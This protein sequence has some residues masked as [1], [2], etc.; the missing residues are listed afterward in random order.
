MSLDNFVAIN[1]NLYLTLL[2][3]EENTIRRIMKW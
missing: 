1:Q 2:D 3:H